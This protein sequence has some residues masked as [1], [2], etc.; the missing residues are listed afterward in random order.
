MI[1]YTPK[2][3][4]ELK[5]YVQAVLDTLNLNENKDNLIITQRV[6]TPHPR[7]A[8]HYGVF[9]FYDGKKAHILSGVLCYN[10]ENRFTVHG[11]STKKI[12]LTGDYVEKRMSSEER[13]VLEAHGLK[14]NELPEKVRD[15]SLKV[16]AYAGGKGRLFLCSEIIED[17]AGNL[18]LMDVN[19]VPGF[20]AVKTTEFAPGSNPKFEDICRKTA[21]MILGC[22]K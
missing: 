14:Y 4:E 17:T 6:D 1:I 10:P 3:K 19:G 2:N 9:T 21:E 16:C 5:G 22:Y 7:Y 11:N 13:K 20:G 18:Y 8:S 15:I 12:P